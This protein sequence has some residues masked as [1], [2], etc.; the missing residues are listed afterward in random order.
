MA[1]E[2]GYRVCVY[3]PTSVL[4]HLIEIVDLCLKIPNICCC[5]WIKPY[6]RW[7]SAMFVRVC[8]CGLS[9]SYVPAWESMRLCIGGW[10][11]WW[12]QETNIWTLVLLVPLSI[13]GWLWVEARGGDGTSVSMNLPVCL[14]P[15]LWCNLM[16][17][18]PQY[19][20]HVDQIIK[21]PTLIIFWPIISV[22]SSFFQNYN[23][24]IFRQKKNPV[25]FF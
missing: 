20:Q 1:G 9:M 24:A 23:Y 14:S 21:S 18:C 6:S 5:F 7:L 13:R 16:H 11:S 22:F 17:D 15:G 19:Q 10:H 25:S 8:V 3:E 4:F 12:E 2:S